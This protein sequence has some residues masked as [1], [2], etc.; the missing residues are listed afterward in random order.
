M[1]TVSGGGGSSAFGAVVGAMV[2]ED[3]SSAFGAVVGATVGEDVSVLR[4][5]I[6]LVS[7]IRLR[8]IQTFSHAFPVCL[9]WI[10]T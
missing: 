5:E 8:S 6:S 7:P 10:R 4:K 3:G 2:G 1:H 9:V